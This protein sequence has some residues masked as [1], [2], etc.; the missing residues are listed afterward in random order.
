MDLLYIGL[1]KATIYLATNSLIRTMIIYTEERYGQHEV[2]EMM[3]VDTEVEGYS[4]WLCAKEF[5]RLTVESC[6]A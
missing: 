5:V 3:F 6:A 2:H 4:S 1:A